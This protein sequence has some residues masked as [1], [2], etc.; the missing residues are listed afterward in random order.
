[1]L[2]SKNQI[3]MKKIFIFLNILSVFI[4]VSCSEDFLERTPYANKTTENFYRN[5]K[6]AM[7]ALTAVYDVLQYGDYDN[8]HIISEVMSD[9]CFGGAGKSDNNTHVFWDSFYS[10]DLNLNAG[11]WKKILQRYIQG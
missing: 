8:F 2:N 6:D 3:I 4:M 7:E 1:M 9:D 5:S 11:P 10:A